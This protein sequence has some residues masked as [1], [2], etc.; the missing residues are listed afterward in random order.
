[1][2]SYILSKLIQGVKIMNAY[3]LM[4]LLSGIPDKATVL[5]E[6][7]FTLAEGETVC[8][9]DVIGNSSFS[10]NRVTMDYDTNT[11]TLCSID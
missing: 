10:I 3:Q 11:L 2:C 5:M 7:D 8:V 4:E 6:F 9:Y 1:M